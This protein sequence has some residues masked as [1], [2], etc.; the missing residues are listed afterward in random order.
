MYT[1][2]TSYSS[3]VYISSSRPSLR[4]FSI[5]SARISTPGPTRREDRPL[6]NIYS[7]QITCV[8]KN[9]KNLPT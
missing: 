4:L 9:P 7:I 1:H 2:P 8:S 6:G 3:A 5:G